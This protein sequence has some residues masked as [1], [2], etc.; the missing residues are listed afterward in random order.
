MPERRDPHFEE[1]LFDFITLKDAATE[2][3]AIL[4]AAYDH[5]YEDWKRHVGEKAESLTERSDE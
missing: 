3:G 1:W 4:D 5:Y 2:C